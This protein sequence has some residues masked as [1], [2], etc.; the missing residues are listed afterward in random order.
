V[1][2]QRRLR[3]SD[4]PYRYD[5]VTKRPLCR[6]CGK[7]VPPPKQTFCSEACVHEYLLRSDP[8]YLRSK[9]FERDHGVCASCGLDTV[10]LEAE[11][12]KLPYGSERDARKIALGFPKHRDTL[13]DADHVQPVVEGGGLC[14]LSNMATKCIPCH[15][16]RRRRKAA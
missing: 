10:K 8:R 6:W 2:T 9:V 1:S 13:W 3:A 14:D 15:V 5:P 12:R 11:L 4:R 7:D 16:A